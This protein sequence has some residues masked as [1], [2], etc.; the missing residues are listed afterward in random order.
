MTRIIEA[1]LFNDELELLEARFQEGDGIVDEWV[2]IEA[3]E[4]F[5]GEPKPYHFAENWERFGPWAGRI[6]VLY[7]ELPPGTAWEREAAQRDALWTYL[8]DLNADDVIVLS[9]GDELTR[10]SCW[11]EIVHKTKRGSINL[12]K[13]TW[14]YTL[15][16]AL[17]VGGPDITSFRS[18]AARVEYVF[19]RES[20]SNWADDISFPTVG[21]SGWHLS[22]LGGPS[23]LLSKI[24][25][26]SH[27][28]INTEDWATYE[29]CQRIIREGIDLAPGRN[30]VMTRTDPAG[31]D[32]L[33]TEGVIKYPWLLTGEDP[34]ILP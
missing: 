33:V 31:P 15:T 9:D 26:S 12:H 10:A 11:D 21:E 20:V 24:R 28:E 8:V 29:N 3:N 18:K 7:V 1:V 5:T 13:P 19:A 27:Q 32:W 25:A 17:P 30:A 16:W 2:I 34:C 4:T 23:R 6:S 22:A 14:Y